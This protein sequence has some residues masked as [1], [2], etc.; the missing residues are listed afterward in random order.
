MKSA[1]T[2]GIVLLAAVVAH[3][4]SPRIMTYGDGLD[5][6]ASDAL[7][8]DDGGI[9]IVGETIV[10]FEP[11][12]IRHILLLRLDAEGQ[13]LW[14]RTYGEDRSSSGHAVSAERDGG[15]IVSGAIQSEDGDDSDVYLLRVDSDGNEI[16][17]TTFGTALNEVG[18]R[19][20]GCE[21]TGY[22]IVGN[23]VDPSDVVADPSAAGYAGFSGRSNIYV[24]RTDGQ[25]R[26]LWSR[27]MESEANTIAFGSAPADD[28]GIL[29][30]SGILHYPVNDNDIVLT[31]LS[32][33]GDEIWS[34]TWTTGSA[35]GYS[36]I[37]TSDGGYAISG[38]RSVP[39]DPLREKADALV[40]KVD[41]DGN[42]TWLTTYGEPHLMEAADAV[43]ETTDGGFVSCGW[44]T[45]DL[46]TPGDDILIAAFD[47]S[48]VLL[49]EDLIPSSAHNLHV[50]IFQHSDGS[51]V[52]VGSARQPG[53]SFRIQLIE[54]DP[55]A[56]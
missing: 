48:G 37:S 15:F 47:R 6:L 13:L 52:I 12:M 51:H 16:W 22:W 11:E 21:S 44:Q 30:L 55:H 56:E 33:D 45:P 9:V 49:W 41:A 34:R 28:G 39:G 7:L 5:D 18:G 20:V 40:I 17:S 31:K 23:S 38:L 27:R 50:R 4:A 26:E 8:L 32:I 19:V 3:A 36:I 43:T 25:G 53:Q 46:F 42:E 29:I 54:I 2:M 10:A 35:L 1:I 24:V 14:T